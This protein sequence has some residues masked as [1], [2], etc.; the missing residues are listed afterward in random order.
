MQY[1]VTEE[2]FGKTVGEVLR[3]SLFLTKKQVS[4]AKFLPGGITLNGIQVRVSHKFTQPGMLEVLLEPDSYCFA[5]LLP[6]EGNLEILYEDED[7]MVVNKPSGMVCHPSHGHYADTLANFAAGYCQSHGEG[8][9]IRIVGRLDKDTSGA[10]VFAKNRVAAQRLAIQRTGGIFQK[11]YLAFAEG[12]L[13]EKQGEITLPIR[14]CPG[15]LMKMQTHPEGA[16]ACTGYRV[17]EEGGNMSVILC[18]LKTGRTHQ[19]RVHMAGIGHPILGDSLYGN[20]ESAPRLGLHAWKV[21]F[22]QPFTGVQVA[23]IAD[24]DM[25]GLHQ[26]EEKK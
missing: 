4:R 26:K 9:V 5:Q 20:P 21:E 19:I 14:K 11:T 18:K 8:S 24:T 3:K 12:I 1:P 6:S 16:K 2:V 10:V 25:C 7:V 22:M 13:E 17:I 23:V 15:S